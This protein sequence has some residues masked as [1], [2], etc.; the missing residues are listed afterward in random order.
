MTSLFKNPDEAVIQPQQQLAVD[1]EAVFMEQ[2]NETALQSNPTFVEQ[3]FRPFRNFWQLQQQRASESLQDVQSA[4]KEENIVTMLG[5]GTLGAL[6]F[7]WS[8]IDSFGRALVGDPVEDALKEFNVPDPVA[9]VAGQT[10][11]LATQVIGPTIAI[12]AIQALRRPKAVSRV[13]QEL[14]DDAERAAVKSGGFKTKPETAPDRFT[15]KVS[16]DDF[17][18]FTPEELIGTQVPER[19]VAGTKGIPMSRIDSTDDIKKVLA[20]TAER[21]KQK[22]TAAARGVVSQKETQ[23]QADDLGMTVDELLQRTKGQAFNAPETTAARQLNISTAAAVQR[24]GKAYA[25]TGSEAS[26]IAFYDAI[27]VNSAVQE[28]SLAAGA[29]IGRAL[30]AWKILAKEAKD[31]QMIDDFIRAAIGGDSR[32]LARKVATLQTPGQISK[33]VRDATQF[34]TADKMLEVWINWLLSGPQTHA[35]NVT[36]NSLTAAWTLPEHLIASGLGA[37]RG[38]KKDRI[39]AREVL[40]R[41]RGFVEGSK[42]GLHAAKHAFKTE[43]LSDQMLKMD[44]ARR[45]AISGPA[46]KFIRIPTRALQAEDEFFKAIGYRME[47]NARAMRSGLSKGLQGDDLAKHVQA[48]KNNPTEEVIDQAIANSRYLTFTKPLGEAG[49]AVLK[50]AN[51]H[52]AFR[53]VMPFIRTPVNIVK[54]AG[55]RTPLAVFSKKVRDVIKAGGPEA[56]L[57]KARILFGT[58]AGTAVGMLG[59]EGHITGGGPGNPAQRRAMFA[60]GWQP[61]SIKMGDQYY[62]FN[63][64]EPLGIL[65]GVAADVAEISAHATPEEMDQIAGMVVGSITKNLVNKTYLQGLSDLVEA[66]NDPDRYGQAYLSRFIGTA[67][68]TGVAQ[69]ARITDPVMRSTMPEAIDDPLLANAQTMINKIKSRIPGMSP[70]LPPVR[71]MWG[72]PIKLSPGIAGVIPIYM[73]VDRNDKASDE[74]VRLK[75]RPPI[76]KKTVKGAKLS[77][78]EYDRYAELY[79]KRAKLLADQLVNSKGWEQV[80]KFRKEELLKKVFRNAGEI[81]RKQL[82]ADFPEIK[83]RSLQA[84]QKER[85]SEER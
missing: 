30:N 4:L 6:D 5:R 67:V 32:E 13:L 63:R 75:W 3:A 44:V 53:L 76:P 51:S 17:A 52:P 64:F 25:E 74:I 82:F 47:L 7:L 37:F 27:A 69:V 60:S 45:Q 36:S 80:P 16:K 81:A 38:D 48:F 58:G 49:N 22:F 70:D 56:D 78:S 23:R 79:G 34:S 31:A 29:E 9:E 20:I 28:Q 1:S 54:F 66:V 15:A 33:A 43:K 8:P 72:E 35:V 68:P 84:K 65:F 57:A 11:S 12:N 18:T 39:F 21:N 10:A 50:F 71:N 61:Y 41:M 14:R 46:G 55:E 73:S 62:A 2:A 59:F 19:M 42:E 85:T 77:A 40:A 83:R 26:K 24:A